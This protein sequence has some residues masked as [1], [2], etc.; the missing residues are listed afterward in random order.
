[1]PLLPLFGM[2]SLEGI[3]FF[4]TRRNLSIVFYHT[5]WYG[6]VNGRTGLTLGRNVIHRRQSNLSAL[7][8]VDT[9]WFWSWCSLAGHR[10]DFCKSFLSREKGELG[11][12]VQ[13]SCRKTY[14]L[15]P[16]HRR[17]QLQ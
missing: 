13:Y 6:Q 12:T 8:A 11:A 3:P 16:H 2:T 4:G 5:A 7:V 14:S 1:L 9:D 17:L 10:G 15:Q